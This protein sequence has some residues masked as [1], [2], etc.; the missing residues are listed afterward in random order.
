[1]R[2]SEAWPGRTFIIRL[3]DGEVLHEVLEKFAAD[4]GIERAYLIAVGGAGAG[5]TLVVGPEDPD[6]RPVPPLTRV[7]D[8]VH[9]IAGVGTLFPGADGKPLL[10]IH[11]ACGRGGETVTGCGRTGV[12]VW[13]VAEVI[14]VELTG[15][16]AR[17][18]LD[19]ETGF[20]LLQ[21]E[22]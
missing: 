7:L 9:E 10:H 14:M 2:Y 16:G 22:G 15:T 11:L 18:K 20:E 3:E 13:Q 5:S 6:E 12:R 4:R 19:P 17:R 8:G 21:P 1:M